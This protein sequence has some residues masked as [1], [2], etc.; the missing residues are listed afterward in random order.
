MPLLRRTVPLRH[1][2][3]LPALLCAR[4]SAFLLLCI[5]LIWASHPL[6]HAQQVT[7]QEHLSSSSTSLPL[8]DS[9]DAP[10]YPLAQTVQ[11]DNP[12]TP[13]SIESRTQSRE[14]DHYTLAGDVEIHYRDRI[15][16]ADRI[17][18]D[19]ATGELSADGHLRIEGGSSNEQITASR[20][21]LNLKNDTGRFFDVE[22]SVGLK[23]TSSK[24]IYTSGNPFLF[25]GRMV[26]KLGPDHYEV[27]NG[28]VTSCRLPH[29]DWRLY[30]GKFV[31]IDDKAV[32]HNSTFRLINVPILYLPY[33]THPVDSDDRQSG[34]L[35]PIFG[36][37]SS[38][39]FI[40]G[41]QVY[42]AINRSM[43][44][45]VGSEFFSL[46]GWSQSA[47]FRY[48][49]PGRNFLTARYNGLLDRGYT[50]TNGSYTNQG[51]QEAT[52][53]TRYDI[54]PHTRFVAD[55]DYLSSYIYRQA[56]TENFNQ[57]VSSDIVSDAYVTH[58]NHFYSAS[59]YADR[60]QGLKRVTTG[61]QVRIFHAPSLDFNTIEQPLQHTHL[62]WSLDAQATGLKRVQQNFTSSGIIERFDLHPHFAY[63]VAFNGWRLRPSV[64]IRDTVYTRSRLSSPIP[65]A[66]PVEVTDPL[67]RKDV[68]AEAELRAPVLE[69]TFEL[70]RFARY[71]GTQ[72]KH[73]IEPTATY[74]FVHGVDN[75]NQVLRFDPVDVVT[76]TN[77]LEYS[78]TQRIYLKHRDTTACTPAQA[79][80]DDAHCGNEEM[81]RWRLSQKYFFDPNFGG[82][83]SVGRRNV[84]DT[85][86][87]FSGIAFLTDPRNISPLLSELRLR[88]SAN[89]D[90][91]WDFDY[92]T[93][94]KKFTRNNVFA[95]VHQG[96]Y[97]AGL[98][99]AYLN[100][101]GRFQTQG[102]VSLLSDFSQVR[103]LLG[104]G[105][106]TKQGLSLAANAGVDLNLESLQYGAV[107]ASYN[108]DC[109]GF[110]VEYRKFELGPVR[111][112]N[113]YRFNFTLA[114]VG[115]AGNLRR[116]ERLF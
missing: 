19:A 112:E 56:F 83:V 101:P 11:P 48:K 62:L 69:R 14:G 4:K 97:F 67:N 75:Y 84:F 87:N 100:A 8:P 49:G 76:N 72:M 43:D 80:S 108:F 82:A 39:G 106:P 54:S 65:G 94:V 20:G 42:F 27:Y 47:V 64:A 40:V 88:T 109:C 18:Y 24:I 102:T 53:S 50:P 1:L 63:P 15:I 37:S 61:E 38:K 57:A 68:E 12:S 86:L 91:E 115:T 92:D 85:T 26:V 52:L 78:V 3:A 25:T 29:P 6:L 35:I 2:P 107:Q 16:H 46:R 77:E 17:D 36:Q 55:V 98:S 22:G 110:S 114:N 96:N 41:E 21:T 34:L 104:Y 7:N 66:V 90:L 33:V 99:Y 71:L 81:L 60:Y 95:D 111:N 70:P 44:L 116:A 93:G 45:T 31:I 58:N 23:K 74:R 103:I 30:S 32:A 9:P 89:T 59:I 13:V 28:T 113:S 10:Q 5:T 51:G 73:T 79:T 105:T